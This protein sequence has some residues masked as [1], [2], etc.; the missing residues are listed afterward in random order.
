M[1]FKNA[2][3][4]VEIP[5]TDI[6]RA[7]KFYETIFGVSLIPVDVQAIKMRMFPLESPMGVGGAIVYNSEFYKQ[8][9]L[10]IIVAGPVTL[11]KHWHKKGLSFKGTHYL[12][13][14]MFRLL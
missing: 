2:I 9:A 6:E 13:R 3:S 11:F 7:Q 4:W 8:F 10:F 5:S 14:S 12:F 1:I